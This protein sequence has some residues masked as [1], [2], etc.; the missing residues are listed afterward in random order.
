MPKG[1]STSTR[2]RGWSARTAFV[3]YAAI[4]AGIVALDQLTKYLARTQLADGAA[5]TVIP[6]LFDFQLVY[7]RGAA[8]GM[9]Q[10]KSALFVLIA[11]V[12][13]AGSLVYLARADERRALEVVLLACIG[14][15]GVGN[16]IDR[17]IGS[18]AVTDFI[19]TTFID[20]PVFNVADI[21]VTLGCICLVVYLFVGLKEEARKE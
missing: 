20:F 19:A 7:N 14:G 1:A 21:A 2:P 17:C 11:L 6:G 18:H 9:M 3:A 4:L 13:V 5:H 15:G 8:F 12:L 16:L 10:G